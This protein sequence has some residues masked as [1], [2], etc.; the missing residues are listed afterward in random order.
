MHITKIKKRVCITDY[1]LDKKQENL[2]DNEYKSDEYTC[3]DVVSEELQRLQDKT[4]FNQIKQGRLLINLS[5]DD[6][7]NGI[8]LVL[9]NTYLPIKRTQ[10]IKYI[11]A[12]SYMNYKFQNNQSTDNCYKLGIE[13]VFLITRLESEQNREKLEQFALDKELTV[14]KLSQLVEILNGTNELLSLSKEFND[15]LYTQI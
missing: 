1:K 5:H 2:F 8:N 7:G 6:S 12:Y 10:A 9:K 3:F 14:T 4:F 11:A 13:K 15:S